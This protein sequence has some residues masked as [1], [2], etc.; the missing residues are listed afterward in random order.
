MLN[1][2]WSSLDDERKTGGLKRGHFAE[3]Y[4]EMQLMLYGFEVYKTIVDDRGIDYI[5]R[6]PEEE[7][8]GVF[9]EIQ[10]KSVTPSKTGSTNIKIDR[11]KFDITNKRLYLLAIRWEDDK[12]P[13]MYIIPATEWANPHYDR[14]IFYKGGKK[15]PQYNLKFPKKN[16][17]LLR[18][19]KLENYI[20]KIM[21]IKN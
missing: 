18:K 2:K 3:Y 4:A 15:E 1:K 20:G 14:K 11:D 9:Y 7:K 5:I 13:E 19:Y 16:P 8:M 21:T 17:D 6:K 12:D 10:V